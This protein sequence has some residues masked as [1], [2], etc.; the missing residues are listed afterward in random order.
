ME[1]MKAAQSLNFGVLGTGVVGQ[2]LGS[3]LIALGHHVRMGARQAGND[4]AAAWTRAAGP[5]ASEGSFADAASFGTVIFNCTSG[6]GTLSAL[7]A[8]KA[9]NLRD[10]VLV[11]VSN[12]LDFSKG[13]P[14]SLFTPSGDSLAEQIQRAYPSTRVVKALNTITAS[15]MVD[16]ARVGGGE[17]DVFLC[18]NDAAAKAQVAGLLR[19]GFGWQTVHDFGDITGARGLE[20]YVLFWVRAWGTLGT[21]EFNLRLVR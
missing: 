14:P 6:A 13:M 9:D 10:K 18:G 3:K 5:R 20:A 4:K 7:G 17:H 16:P 12:P 19:D 8:A 11:D 15:V 1:T 2:T 21:A